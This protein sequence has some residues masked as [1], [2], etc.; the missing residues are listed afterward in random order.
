M[1]DERPPWYT[2]VLLVLIV[3]G[4]VTA[5]WLAVG[6]GAPRQ[7][8]AAALGS[9]SVLFAERA[10]ALFSAYLLG[11]IVIWRAVS[12]ELPAEIRGLKYAARESNAETTKAIEGLVREQ[13]MNRIRL[14]M[15][16]EIADDALAG[17][18]DGARRT[19]EAAGGLE[20]AREAAARLRSIDF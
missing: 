15:V 7:L 16:E 11:L 6:S 13:Q 8:P 10:A 4:I 3:G 17:R 5:T 1:A 19:H 14:E 12:G 20:Q 2:P 9:K 18:L